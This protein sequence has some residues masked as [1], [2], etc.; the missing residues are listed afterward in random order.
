[1]TSLF[2]RGTGLPYVDNAHACWVTDI[3]GNRYLDAASGALVVNVGHGDTR[4]ASAI[5]RQLDE[6]AYVHASAF[7]SSALEGYAESLARRLPMDDPAIFPVSGGS[8]AVETALKVA[9]AYHLANDDPTRSIV[10]GRELSYHGNTRGALDVSG[11]VELRRPYLPWL[12]LA[13]RVSAVLEYRCPNP[14]H[15]RGCARWHGAVL[16][17]E[18]EKLGADRVAAFIAEPVGGATSGAA[19]PPDGYWETVTEVC[20]RHGVLVIADE[21]MTGF[22]RTGAWFASEHFGLRPDIMVMAKGASSGYWPLGV[23]AFSGRVASALREGGLVHGFTFSH[24]VVGAAAGAA[25]IERI[26]ELGLVE[27]A[28]TKGT[29]LEEALKASIGDHPIVGDIRGMGLMW[30]VELVADRDTR[31]PFPPSESMAARLTSA[32]RDLG[33]LVYPSTGSA[34]EGAGDLVMIGPP[35]I[36]RDHEIEMLAGTLAQ[37]LQRLR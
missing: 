37:S 36:I 21:V 22:G 20:A 7:N 15:P 18:I 4:V 24:H 27:R 5:R 14:A 33:L 30:A 6:V 35:L 32:A 12:G 2:T 29:I 26:D 8:E 16:D 11:R 1:M 28:R 9:R 31:R 13:T 19:V 17:A 34:G 25:V 10:I 23:C 3:A